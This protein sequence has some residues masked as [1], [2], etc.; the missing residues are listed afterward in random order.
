MKAEQPLVNYRKMLVGYDGSKNARRALDR[1]VALAAETGASLRIVV[2]VSTIPPVYG[3][4]APYYPAN[5]AEEVAKEGKNSM[6]EAIARA[7]QSVQKASGAVMD[8]HPAQMILDSAEK[9]GSDLIVIGRRGI[10]GVERFLL[11]SVS[12]SVVNHSKC[13]VLV[14]K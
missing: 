2:A 9:E 6:D 3:T 13:D 7:K 4:S 12:S 10:S 8:G 11:G 14:V 5:Y 1:A